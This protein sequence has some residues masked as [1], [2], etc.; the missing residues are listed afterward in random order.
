M[1]SWLK[2]PAF[3]YTI[4]AI[5]VL[6]VAAQPFVLL[7]SAIVVASLLMF[8]VV[9]SVVSNPRSPS[10]F[11]RILYWIGIFIGWAATAG[12]F[13]SCL[14]MI[15][16][17]QD[18]DTTMAVASITSLVLWIGMIYGSR[19]WRKSREERLLAQ[20]LE[21][22]RQAQ[23]AAEFQKGD[24]QRRRSDA[25]ANC[26]LLYGVHAPEIGSRFSRQDLDTWI[27][28]HMAD[29]QDPIV[30]ERRGDQLRRLIEHHREQ[31]KPTPRFATIEELARWFQ[32]QKQRVESLPIEEKTKRMHL[33]ELNQRYAELTGELLQKMKP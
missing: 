33:V 21:S 19:A 20:Q 25:R 6:L 4:L 32:E 22:D 17:F 9:A 18:H 8:Q 14:A 23:R 30:V 27:K 16:V 2:K 13:A 15:G 3:W 1:S 12:M 11:R 5:N 28:K 10:R 26:E 7:V 24:A 29:D 31:V